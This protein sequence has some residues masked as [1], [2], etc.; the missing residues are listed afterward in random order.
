MEGRVKRRVLER[1]DV[2]IE[3]Q[4]V[5]QNYLSGGWMGWV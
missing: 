1:D 2:Q 3:P 4:K 5:S